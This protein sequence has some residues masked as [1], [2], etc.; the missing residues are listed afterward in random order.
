MPKDKE[1][2]GSPLPGLNKRVKKGEPGNRDVSSQIFCR[3]SRIQRSCEGKEKDLV[4]GREERKDRKA[5]GA[6]SAGA[7][8]P[9]IYS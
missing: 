7:Q 2:R 9:A 8:P 1:R 6:R 5:A 4:K 3:F